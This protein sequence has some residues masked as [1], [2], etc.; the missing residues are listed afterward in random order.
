MRT[1][2]LFLGF[3]SGTFAFAQTTVQGKVVDQNG[4]PVANANIVVVGQSEGAV[5][6]FDGN[7]AFSSSQTPPFSIRVSSLGY[8]TATV[9]FGGSTVTVVL[10]EASTALDEIVISASRT[11]ERIFES[12]VSVER[13]G[14]AQIQNATSESFYGS[15]QNLKG[16]DINT[17]SL[18]FQSINTRGFATFANTRFLQL[19]DGMDNTAPGLNFVLGNLVGMSELDVQSVEILPGASSALYG[20][21]AFNGI[22]F[23]TSKDPF[24]TEGISVYGKTGYTVQDAAGTN[25]YSD[26][27]VR[28]AK[29]FSDKLA[30]KA[31][32][33]FMQG[34][35]WHANDRTDISEGALGYN[36]SSPLNNP[37]YDGLNVYGDEVSSTLNFD[38]FA[39]TPAG[40]FG[41][42]VVARTGYDEAD[43]A[44]Y[45]AQSVKRDVAVHYRPFGDDLEVVYNYRRGTGTTIYQGANRYAVSGFAMTQQKLEIKNDNFFI[46][47]YITAEDSGDAYDTRFA[48]IN[49]NRQWSPDQKWFE[50]YIR[51]YLLSRQIGKNDQD[52]HRAARQVA[53][54]P[55]NFAGTLGITSATGFPHINRFQPG[56]AEFNNA[57]A[58]VKQDGDFNTGARFIDNTKFRHI[59]GNYNFAHLIND[60]ADLQVGGSYRQYELNSNGTIFTDIDGPITYS[61]YGAYTQL[62]KTFAD[63]RAKFTAS[64][65]Y[66]KNEF[67]DGFVSPRVSLG[68]TLGAQRNHNIRVSAQ[69]GFRN[70][71]TQ[72]FF[73]G[74]DVGNAILVGGAAANLDRDVRTFPVSA[75]AQALGIPATST[76]VGRAAYENSF[77]LS[78]VQAG[79][80]VAK[81]TRQVQAE[82][83]DVVEAGYRGKVGRFVIDIS[84][85]YNSYTNFN[86]AELK[87]VP[88]Y[89]TAGDNQ[90]SLLALQNGD[91]KVYQAYTNTDVPV[92]SYGFVAGVD[93]KVA[94]FDVGVNYTYTALDFNRLNF[95]DFQVGLNTPQDRFK[96]SLG[97]AELFKNFG[98]NLNYRYSGSYLWE[99][100]FANGEVPAFDVLDAAMTYKLPKYDTVLKL[101]GSNVAGGDYIT[102]IGTGMIGSIYYAAININF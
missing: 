9:S 34:E 78:S 50:D 55:A 95:P 5:A 24:E 69:T 75:Q 93:T 6:D 63:E 25:E 10:N 54:Y 38:F 87:V 39:G 45:G 66:D 27:G 2:L 4:Q 67:L 35:D 58:Q 51:G 33:T 52:A 102:A 65:R 62:Q 14:L 82:Q 48:A 96:A 100:S 26:F 29:R 98:F 3:I 91:F 73:I 92:K 53:D 23:M 71:T 46:R 70:P 8:T 61:E 7:F 43:V 79:A 101:G 47:G 18:T 74:L 99:A 64:A 1:L 37:G 90:L 12:P 68:Y 72:D 41:S 44:D 85:Y 76:V 86:A 19:V 94:G 15:L 80:P 56:S 16:V 83:I 60:W 21:G 30:V 89:G 36:W 42:A 57:F 20:A 17:N 11:P 81:T 28:V 31:N 40:T 88:L 22:L 49:I 97:H 59:N 13:F 77:S 84:A 32:F